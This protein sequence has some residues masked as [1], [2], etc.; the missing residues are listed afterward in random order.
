MLR[1]AG[2]K[3][4]SGV[5]RIVARN[6][7][8]QSQPNDGAPEAGIQ[9][10][11]DSNSRTDPE[12]LRP[13]PETIFPIIVGWYRASRDH[14][15]EFRQE[16]AECFDLKAGHQW[17]DTDLAVLAD[18][19]RPA[20]TLNMIDKFLASVEGLEINNRQETTYLPRQV[21]ASGVT[22]L[23]TS[24]AQWVRQECDAEDEETEAFLDAATGGLGATQSRM[25]YDDDPDGMAKIE[26]IDPLELFPD[27][28]AR[29]QNLTD[30]RYVIRV[31]DVPVGPAEELFPEFD[32]LA[33]H[34]QWAED[35]P[36]ATRSPHNA[37]LA[38]Y[39]RIDQSA[40]VDRNEQLIR[41]VEVEW[42]EYVT[43]WRV[44]DPMTGRYFRLD[45]KRAKLFAI[46]ARTLGWKPR[47]VK[48]RMRKYWKAIVG[49][50]VLKIMDGPKKGGFTYKFITGKRD[51]TKGTWYG[52][53]R[54]MRDPQ[55]WLNKWVSQGMHIF[56][57]NAKGG[58][59]I[60]TDAV[61]DIDETRDAWAE[62]D[63]II[64]VNPGGLNKIKA[65]DPAQFPQ[66][67]NQMTEMALASFPQV[68][69]IPTEI[70]GQST[71][72]QP[73]MAMLEVGRRQAGMNVLA[74][75]FNAKRRYHKEQGRL[76]LWMIQT[77]IA[78]GR[79]I[80]IGG[81]GQ[82][83]YVP[84]VHVPGLTEYDVI[85]DDAPTSANMKDK[86]WNAL[87]QMFPM[88]RGIPEIPPQFYINAL[89]YSPAPASFVNETQQ[90]M[91]QPRPPN[92]D[93]QAK[94]GLDQAKTAE[95]QGRAALH[96]A[97]VQHM[98]AET[99]RV[100]MVTQLAPV[101]ANL[102]VLDQQSKIENTRAQ[103]ALAL[104]KA[105]IASDDMRFQHVMAAVDALLRSHGAALDHV[106]GIHDRGMDVANLQQ[107]QQQQQIDQQQAQQ[108]Q[109][110]SS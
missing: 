25:E 34:A 33:L 18:Q 96:Q 5:R 77:Y 20:F 42:W 106:Q 12:D 99:G 92:P 81:E 83:Q 51:V 71:S 19:S 26:R 9:A 90:I 74:W 47:M 14:F 36:D 24:A 69:G 13:D 87:M 94:I 63:S 45:D 58:L 75:I 68:T 6:P 44:E 109:G 32:A 56:N 8:P 15:Q 66:Q 38:P 40:D 53:V 95:M 85:V 46:R 3:P 60:E 57:T 105:G 39:Y 80:R 31:K 50:E 73:N 102:K 78:D 49:S 108:P 103:A 7:S 17:T 43:C 64:E 72:A 84:L 110:A 88:I 91:M 79:L 59:I 107:Q 97:E 70:F 67:L 41:L 62:A 65:K 37:R 30:A 16:M 11:G 86:V 98:G 76:L 54:A 82:Q 22:D 27:A 52:I 89:K 55:L 101:E 2:F 48:D 100:Q 23:L 28:N 35:Q 21:G 1:L 104:Q 93:A 10:V 61:A 29:K 4:V